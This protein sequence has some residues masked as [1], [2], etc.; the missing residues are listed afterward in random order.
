MKPFARKITTL[1][2]CMILAVSLCG[3]KKNDDSMG[4]KS[5]DYLAGGTI[6]ASAKVFPIVY[7]DISMTIS[8]S[9]GYLNGDDVWSLT[10]Y[11][12]I[13]C[14]WDDTRGNGFLADEASEFVSMQRI[15]SLQESGEEAD[16]D[17]SIDGVQI[18]SIEVKNDKRVE[19][20]YVVKFTGQC[21]SEGVE[22]GS[23]E[24]IEG[25]YF[26]KV[27]GKW[28]EDGIGFALMAKAGE[29]TYEQDE[30]TGVLTITPPADYIS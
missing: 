5:G 19:V 9:E 14:S 10:H 4:I 3:C 30:I 8:D 18:L 27:N 28:Y 26:E 22:E 7:D 1:C 24:A 15:Q 20:D 6:P 13:W 16:R 29:I 21:P 17:Y 2:I 12:D 25:L 23:Y 11:V